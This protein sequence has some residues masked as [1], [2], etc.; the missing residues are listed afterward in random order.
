MKSIWA[1]FLLFFSISPIFSQVTGTVKDNEGE[2]LPFV[3]IYVKKTSNGTTSNINGEYA[4]KLDAGDYDITF[5]YVG[6]K[7]VNK[8]VTVLNEELSLDVVLFPE[9]Y[10]LEEIVISANAEDPAYAIIR[11]AQEKRKYYRDNSDN[12]ECDVYVRGF[13][14]ILSAPEKIMGINIGDL[15]G[16]IDTSSRQG[17]V[18]LSESVSKIYQKVNKSKEVMYSSKI[19]GDDAGY[20]FNSAQEMDFNFYSNKVS[21][22]KEIITPIAAGA[23]SYYKYKLEGAQIDENGQ[24]INKIKVTPKNDMSPAFFG[25]IYINEDLWNIHSL[26]LGVT[27][28]STQI[29]FIDTLMFK[30]IFIPVENDRWVKFTNVI[31]FK[32]SAVGFQFV[33]NFAA[34]YSNYILDQVDDSVFSNEVFK[35]EKE[36]NE[37]SDEYWDEIRPIPLTVE[38][39]VDYVRK[40]SIRMVRESP[41]YLDSIDRENNKFKTTTI[42][43]GYDYQNSQKKSKFS[44]TSPVGNISFNTIQGWNSSSKITYSKAYNKSRTKRLKLEGVVSYGLTEKVWRPRFKIDF[45]HNRYNNLRFELVGGKDLEQ[46][47]RRNPISNTLNSFFTVVFD[48]NY[49]KSFDKEFLGASVMRDLGNT[50]W[51]SLSLNYQNRSPLINNYLCDSNKITSNDPRRP[52]TF[53]LPSFEN[54]QALIFRAALRVK[55]GEE[56]WN[57]PDRKFKAGS[58]WPTLW[59][60]YKKAIKGLGGDLAYDLV[61]ASLYKNYVIGTLGNS[62]FYVSGGSFVR[63]DDDMPFIDYFHFLGNQTHV[64]NPG[65]YYNRFLMLP[66]YTHS[67]NDRFVEAHFQHNFQ[68]ILL[69]KV[70]LIKQLGWHLAAGYKFMDTADQEAY[71]EFHVGLD[72]IGIKIFRL[73]RVDAV[74]SSPL[75]NTEKD[76]LQFGLILGIKFDLDQ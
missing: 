27:K 6:F 15:D 14:K 7:T 45:R 3:N 46:F 34:V 13:N 68:G 37:R 65:G 57:Y 28:K 10:K 8:N 75:A 69:G 30:Q 48:Q 47:S 41:E 72:N 21:I 42:L 59:L 33:G 54:H 36:A 35:V 50:F 43:T 24:L 20:S 1:F 53:N 63:K 11:K 67:T 25:H 76:K 58:K 66:Y 40:D 71:H 5:Q 23:M 29:P 16:M 74:W 70:P 31:K 49:M 55:I 64:G 51:G 32:M 39:K 56:V 52:F 61:Y 62:D 18:Y 12:F 73:F 17:V 2:L 4:L 9:D 38:E 19:S 44:I 26:E 22:N 60:Y